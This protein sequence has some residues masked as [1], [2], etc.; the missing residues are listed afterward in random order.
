MHCCAEPHSTRSTTPH[1]HGSQWL[2]SGGGGR[3]DDAAACARLPAAVAAPDKGRQNFSQSRHASYAQLGIKMYYAIWREGSSLDITWALG[4]PGRRRRA[5]PLINPHST[6]TAHAHTNAQTACTN[7]AVASAGASV[8]TSCSAACRSLPHLHTPIA[9]CFW[10]SGAAAML[11]PC[12]IQAHAA[13]AIADLAA[14]TP[15][16]VSRVG[17]VGGGGTAR[18]ARACTPLACCRIA[19]GLGAG[20]CVGSS[21][22]KSAQPAPLVLRCQS[23]HVGR[24]IACEGSAPCPRSCAAG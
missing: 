12:C 7:V 6:H 17:Q 23:Q 22:P 5:A 11:P 20:R 9:P 19:W 14:S 18:G 13:G 2:R 10:P 15:A 4:Q 8:G 21:P 3:G 16:P 24:Q 1:L